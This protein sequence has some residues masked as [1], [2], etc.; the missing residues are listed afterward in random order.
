MSVASKKII[1]SELIENHK[2]AFPCCLLLICEF[3]NT[4]NVRNRT[5]LNLIFFSWKSH[6]QKPVLPGMATHCQLILVALLPLCSQKSICGCGRGGS[7]SGNSAQSMKA[8]LCH[9]R[10]SEWG[11]SNLHLLL[12]V[13]T[14]ISSGTNRCNIYKILTYAIVLKVSSWNISVGFSLLSPPLDSATS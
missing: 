6:L 1:F 8:S 5:E 2:Q 12:S 9:L 4:P 14:V 10:K 11:Q 13:H 3:K 7:T